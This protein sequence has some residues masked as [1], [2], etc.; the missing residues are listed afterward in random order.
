MKGL[1][2]SEVIRQDMEN[3]YGRNLPIE[4][5]YHSTVL[6]TGA[7]GMLASYLC[8]YLIWL[9]EAKGADIKILV[10]VRNT[11]KC[12]R[13]FGSY[14][15][16]VYF[17]ILEDNL[18]GA[19]DVSGPVDYII[20]AASLASPQY[21]HK[22]PVEVALPNAIGTYYLLEL[23]RKKQAQGFLYFSSGDVYGKMPEGIGA[24]GEDLVGVLDPLDEH[25]CYG[26][27]KRMGEI[28]C[29]S[30]AREYGI[31]TRMARIAHTYAPTMDVENDPRVFASFMKCLL[32][33]EDIVM[34]SD[35]TAKRPFCYIADAV[36]G[37]LL[38]LLKGENGEAYNLANT[39]QFLSIGE[40]AEC[41]V[42]LE[43]EK[44]LKVIRK[45]RSQDDVYMENKQNRANCPSVDRLRALGWQCEYDVKRGFGQVLRYMRETMER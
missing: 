21:Y 17:T 7:T 23:T 3:I 43:P 16:R 36:A 31:P 9:N 1:L 25:S 37:F 40:L 38:M 32:K 41:L 6:I 39:D 10:L 13:V 15:E 5:L 24:F 30:Y 29:A 20:H 28:W 8:Y 4:R 35:G 45:Q 42:G 19:L 34:L 27:S 18:E 11:A 44:G 14:A 22:Y 2:K 33:N 12:I 26:G